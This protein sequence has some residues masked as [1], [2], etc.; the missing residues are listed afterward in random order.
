M[1]LLLYAIRG[2]AICRDEITCLINM[3]YRWIDIDTDIECNRLHFM[4][5]RGRYTAPLFINKI[6]DFYKKN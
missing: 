6:I 1:F 4:L 5:S 3:C 2:T